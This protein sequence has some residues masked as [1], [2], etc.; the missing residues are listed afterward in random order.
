M[1]AEEEARITEEAR[2]KAEDHER[3]GLKVEERVHLS[4]EAR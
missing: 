1:K 3:A 4:L 2:L